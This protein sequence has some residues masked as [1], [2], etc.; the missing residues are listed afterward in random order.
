[1]ERKTTYTLY[2]FNFCFKTNCM[3]LLIKWKQS[4]KL[5]GEHTVLATALTLRILGLNSNPENKIA[6]QNLKLT[7][8][9]ITPEFPDT[10][11]FDFTA[12]AFQASSLVCFH[13][14]RGSF[15]SLNSGIYLTPPWVKHPPIFHCLCTLTRRV[16]LYMCKKALWYILDFNRCLLLAVAGCS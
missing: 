10:Y 8:P 15:C 7:P 3:L 1:M 2:R 16:C 6:S 4:D 13:S 11:W 5:S 14:V 12:A 9:I